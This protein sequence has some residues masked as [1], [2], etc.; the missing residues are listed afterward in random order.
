M[1]MKNLLKFSP[2]VVALLFASCQSPQ[3]SLPSD[4]ELQA[5]AIELSQRFIITDGHVD[6]PYRLSRQR[7]GLTRV[8]DD[9]SQRTERGDFDYVRAKQG[10][11]DAPFM[12]IYIP[13][14]YQERPGASKAYADSLILI[15]ENWL[16]TIPISLH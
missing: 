4:E 15:V 7:F 10:G 1:K 16:Q 5:K 12:S 8:M 14:S 11:L 9:I 2:L 6:I 3:E 13:A